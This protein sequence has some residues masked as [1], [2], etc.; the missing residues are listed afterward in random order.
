MSPAQ[1]LPPGTPNPFDP[2]SLI[3]T[4]DPAQ[5]LAAAS[6]FPGGAAAL[7]FALFWAPAGLPVAY[8]F[9]GLV[10]G[11]PAGIFLAGIPAG[12][13]LARVAGVNPAVTFLLYALSDVLG[14][15]IS[16]PLYQGLRRIAR[17]IPVLHGFARR[18][19][20][21][22]MFGTRVPTAAD[23]HNTGRVAPALFRIG[24]V[25]FGIDVYTAGLLVTGLPLP[26]VWGWA[27]A[28]AGDLIWF[29]ILLVVSIITAAVVDDYRIQIGVVLAAT[30]VVPRVAKRF[31]PAL[32]DPEP[33]RRGAPSTALA[34]ATPQPLQAA[35]PVPPASAPQPAL[36]FAVPGGAVATVLPAGPPDSRT[37][38]A[39][40]TPLPTTPP[41]G[42]T[43]VAPPAKPAAPRPTRE[44]SARSAPSRKRGRRR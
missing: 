24:T 7:A 4:S 6:R 20:K 22:A 3:G 27:A 17:R 13:V 32:R 35:L 11:V 19:M 33:A 43:R 18:M 28:I 36:A 21:V 38:M 41:A 14:A 8:M 39:D 1:A 26:R 10:P 30:I 12:V 9:A 29:T 34:E 23:I 15:L 2:A 25:G 40:P 16:H 44:R 31:V 5:L 37:P 42:W